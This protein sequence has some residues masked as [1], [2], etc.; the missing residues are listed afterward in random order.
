M[1]TITIKGSGSAT[2]KP[3]LIVVALSL[4]S[5]DADYEQAVAEAAEQIDGLNACLESIGF[6]KSSVKTVNFRIDTKYENERSMEGGYTR[7][8]KG[9]VC[10]QELRIE[11]DFDAKRLSEVLQAIAS[12]MA[13]PE[14]NISFTVK[15]PEA[16]CDELLRSACENARRRAKVLCASAGVILGGLVSIDYSPETLSF[17]S[18]TRYSVADDC[19]ASPMRTCKA[20]IDFVPDDV[21]CRDTVT[22]VW[23]IQSNRGFPVA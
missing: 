23:E 18:P 3:D 14:L 8:F 4:E 1:K 21:V 2:A 6:E 11:F 17:T 13:K 7:R 22:F 10:S 19:L 12:C 16:L 15:H 5:I 20:A 9:Y